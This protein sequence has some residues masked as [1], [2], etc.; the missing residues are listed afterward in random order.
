M[1]IARIL[2]PPIGYRGVVITYAGLYMVCA[3]LTW[4]IKDESDPGEADVSKQKTAVW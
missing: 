2:A 4:F 3:V 1:F